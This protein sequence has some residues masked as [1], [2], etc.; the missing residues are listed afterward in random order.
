[1]FATA[2]NE[3]EFCKTLKSKLSQ[4]RDTTLDI[5]GNWQRTKNA[6]QAV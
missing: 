2:V 4:D 1:V 5:F 3:L 6:R